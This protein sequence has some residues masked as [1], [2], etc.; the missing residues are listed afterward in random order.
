MCGAEYEIFSGPSA[1]FLEDEVSLRDLSRMWYQHD[2]VPAHKSK[3]QCTFLTQAFDIDY[4]GQQEWA[5]RSPNLI[6]L[7]F[8][9][10]GFLKSK[11]YEREST[12]NPIYSIESA[13]HA[14]M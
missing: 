7:D 14:G 3:K 5:R 1:D 10:W 9:L 8:I 4:G 2:G 12:R 6:P 13:C 11:V